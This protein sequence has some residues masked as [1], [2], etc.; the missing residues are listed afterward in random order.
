MVPYFHLVGSPM[1]A[2]KLEVSSGNNNET[3]EERQKLLVE[4]ELEKCPREHMEKHVGNEHVENHVE[5][6]QHH[7]TTQQGKTFLQSNL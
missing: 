7:V 2:T 3:E 1:K 4:N 6:E 5:N